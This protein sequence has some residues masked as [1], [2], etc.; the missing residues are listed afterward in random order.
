MRRKNVF[1]GRPLN[2][3]TNR[4]LG[5]VVRRAARLVSHV[6]GSSIGDRRTPPPGLYPLTII[7]IDP[8]QKN[9]WCASVIDPAALDT[10]GEA[11]KILNLTR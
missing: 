10:Q 7:A 1:F 9:I 4:I 5:T 11:K 8:G 6:T 2:L 3:G